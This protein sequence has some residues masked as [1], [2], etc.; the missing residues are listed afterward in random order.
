MIDG[1]IEVTSDYWNIAVHMKQLNPPM[2]I[3]LILTKLNKLNTFLAH[4]KTY[5][6]AIG[7]KTI[8]FQYSLHIILSTWN[9]VSFTVLL[10]ANSFIFDTTANSQ[11]SAE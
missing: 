5:R 4:S 9:C 1:R 3:F 11:I 6:K 10:E 2:K 7:V 8:Y